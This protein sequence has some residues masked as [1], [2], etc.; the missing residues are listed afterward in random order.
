MKTSLKTL[1][2]AA[3][4]LTG[5]AHADA[6]DSD[7]AFSSA[8]RVSFNGFDGLITR[9]AV[10]LG[11]A[12]TGRRVVLNPGEGTEIGANARD[13]GENGLWGARGNPL[14]G[15]TPTPT[16]SGNFLASSSGPVHFSFG[17]AVQSVGA[18]LN[19]YRLDGETPSLLLTAYGQNGAVLESFS[20]SIQTAF[21]SYNEGKFLGFVR[22][23]A[24][25][26][27][28]SVAGSN[29]SLDELSF[30]TPV[31]EPESAA[32]LL[33]GLGLLLAWGRQRRRSA[34]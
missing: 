32:L 5:G 33:G 26:Y 19:Q 21:D 10:E 18:Y 28:F 25:I 12:E 9:D 27:G 2:L 3:C 13:L 34:V 24:D 31:P 20:Y 23:Q 11:L 22:A 30:A 15:L 4:F 6:V 8:L 17:E 29:V 16:G 7:A 1:A 14:D